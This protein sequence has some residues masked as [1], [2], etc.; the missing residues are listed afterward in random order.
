MGLIELIL[1]LVVVSGLAIA[2][3]MWAWASAFAVGLQAGLDALQ[4]E[5]E[6]DTMR[7]R[8]TDALQATIKNHAKP[9]PSAA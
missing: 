6:K 1:V 4:A 9:P 2:L 3:L 5:R 8:T 7:K